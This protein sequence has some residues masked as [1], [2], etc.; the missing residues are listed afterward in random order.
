[1]NS[2]MR[3]W[4]LVPDGQAFRLELTTR[5]LSLPGPGRVLVK[6]QAASLNYRDLIIQKKLAGREAAGRIPLSDGAGEVVAVGPD[7]K[8]VQVGDRV[9]GCFF[10]TWLSGR[11]DM[12]HHQH[13]LGG[14]IDGML[15]EYADLSAE[16]V[17]PIPR[18]LNYAE[19]ACLPCAGL[20][21]WYALMTRG[22]LRPGETVLVLGTG[23][24][25]MFA[26]QLAVSLGCPVTAISSSEDK[27]R[28]C[29]DLGATHTVNYRDFPDWDREVW[30]L[31]GMRGVDHVV[32]VGGPGT[33]G[34]SL[35]CIAP[36]GHIALVGVLTGFGA[37]AASLFPLVGRNARISGIYVGS[38]EDF[39]DLGRFVEVQGLKPVIDRTFA[40]DQAPEAYRWLEGRQHVGKVVIRIGSQ[41]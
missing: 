6:V 37:P 7:V 26:L 33:L 27:L 31:S 36:G 30:R 23:G 15:C 20:T 41:G 29:R 38:R 34:K 32:E 10:Q 5:P 14:T 13:D 12:R 18:T 11:F 22:E 2:T 1:M 21:A 17:V 35:G 3:A 39:L 25:S 24:V 19:A 40:F 28:R 4:H 8:R 16:G 9:A